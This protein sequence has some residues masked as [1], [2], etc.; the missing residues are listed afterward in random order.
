M[1][2]E[3]S[4]SGNLYCIIF[5]HNCMLL[6]VFSILSKKL[7]VNSQI[8]CWW[9]LVFFYFTL[10]ANETFPIILYIILTAFICRFELMLYDVGGYN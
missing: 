4:G 8:Y 9:L 10:L 2:A 7:S 5:K 6:Q 3:I 1:S